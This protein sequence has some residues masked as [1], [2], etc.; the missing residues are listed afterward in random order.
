MT[1]ETGRQ[2]DGTL[3]MGDGEVNTR[4]DE[5]HVFL[6]IWENRQGCSGNTKDHFKASLVTPGC[7]LSCPESILRFSFSHDFS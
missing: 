4:H 3:E 7:H 5:N 1:Q 6:M 2:G